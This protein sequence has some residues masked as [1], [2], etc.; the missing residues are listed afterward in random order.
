MTRDIFILS[1]R[2]QWP[3]GSFRYICGLDQQQILNR[4]KRVRLSVRVMCVL[5][6]FLIAKMNVHFEFSRNIGRS[7]QPIGIENTADQSH[8]NVSENTAAFQKE[9]KN[10]C[11]DYYS[12]SV[13]AKML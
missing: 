10:W 8:A 1:K 7:C 5:H 2:L 11:F 12:Y 6:I 13:I 4:I 3:E 9:Q